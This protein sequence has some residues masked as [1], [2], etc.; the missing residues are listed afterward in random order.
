MLLSW[1]SLAGKL[2]FI[3]FSL[4]LNGKLECNLLFQ[5]SIVEHIHR[6]YGNDIIY[7]YMGDILIAVNP[8]KMM[9]IYGDR[10][11][12][13]GYTFWLVVVP[14]IPKENELSPF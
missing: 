6:R 4:L 12:Q 11:S 9:P 13:G 10:V 7:T 2:V 14:K 5:D 1:C 3:V 8:F